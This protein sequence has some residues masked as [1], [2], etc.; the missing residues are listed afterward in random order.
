MPPTVEDPVEQ[1]ET[2]KLERDATKTHESLQSSVELDRSHSRA[3]HD[4][5]EGQA[6]FMGAV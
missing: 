1:L 5:P 3:E 4:N 6:N 2:V